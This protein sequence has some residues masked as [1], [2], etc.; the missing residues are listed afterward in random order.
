MRIMAQV[1]FDYGSKHTAHVC[2]ATAIGINLS[3]TVVQ[4]LL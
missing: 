3:V 1:R 4:S 2:V